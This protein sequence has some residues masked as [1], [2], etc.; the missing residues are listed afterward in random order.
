M[1]DAFDSKAELSRTYM[2]SYFF[3]KPWTMP[4]QSTLKYLQEGYTAGLEAGDTE[5]AMWNI[6]MYIYLRYSS[7]GRLDS[8]LG[9]IQTY[10][11]QI[12]DLRRDEQSLHLQI[13]HQ[14]ILCLMGK[15]STPTVME[16]GAIHDAKEFESEITSQESKTSL[17]IFKHQQTLLYS[18]FGEHEKGAKLALHKGDEFFKVTAACPPAMEDAFHRAMSLFAM[19]KKS[20]KLKYKQA[21]KKILSTIRKA[22]FRSQEVCVNVVCR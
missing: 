11:P 21:A 5:S 1:Y 3:V 14:A 4:F 18:I 15:S 22:E 8:I 10:A 20:K 13:Y 9:D 16:G 2:I 12:R 6:A 17:M 19:A 7:G